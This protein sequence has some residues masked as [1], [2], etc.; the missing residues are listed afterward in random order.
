[1]EEELALVLAAMTPLRRETV[2]GCEFHLGHIGKAEVA[3][4]CCSIGTIN[5]AACTAA[6]VREF[7]A[8]AVVNIGVAGSM[9]PTLGVLD[10][11]LGSELCFHDAQ[12]DFLEECYPFCS[13]FP[14]DR[15]L[16]RLAEESIA[17]MEGP[18]FAY[19]VG[20][21]ASGDVFVSDPATKADIQRR[22]APLCVEMEGAA[23]AQVCY[24]NHT[25]FLIIRSL[26]DDAGA[27]AMLSFETFTQQAAA[28]SA[29]IVLG[30]ISLGR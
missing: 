10:V 15:A 20:R 19:K 3:A 9:D 17:A 4:V 11:V 6:L 12:P 8:E 5:A 13:L 27:E 2:F 16:L 22:W 18:P 1:M 29:G 26:S 23:V 25:P 21:I 28:H 14:A 30:M 7:G 24:M